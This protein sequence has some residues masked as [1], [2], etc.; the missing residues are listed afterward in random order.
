MSEGKSLATITRGPTTA[1]QQGVKEFTI[2]QVEL[3]KRTICPKSTDDELSL[4]I[5]T[6]ERLGLDP[7]AKQI[8]AVKR[9]SKDGD[10]MSIQ[11]SIDGYRLVAERTGKYEGQVGP[12]WCGNDGIW[13]DV[14]L[15]NGPP[16][17]AKVGVLKKGVREPTFAVARFSSYAQRKRNGD[18][19]QIWEKMP[20]LMIAKCAEALALR[21]VFPAELSG[22][23]T[24]VEMAQEDNPTVIDISEERP[25]VVDPRIL[26]RMNNPKTIELFETLATGMEVTEERKLKALK[27]YKSD[28]KLHEVLGREIEK[29]HAD[30]KKEGVKHEAEK[31]A[32]DEEENDAK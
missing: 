18:L 21:K 5:T 28:E 25:P 24:D 16:M 19:F 26:E 27:R 9:W 2:E 4:F 20:D 29:M 15:G 7:F 3:I 32:S 31:K 11:V 13:H 17:A 30:A 8:F 22:V 6:S 23:Y 14:W 1:L 12:Y 10:V